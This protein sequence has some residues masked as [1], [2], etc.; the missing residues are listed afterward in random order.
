MLLQIPPA[1]R[2]NNAVPPPLP[3]PTVSHAIR[4]CNESKVNGFVVRGHGSLLE[5]LRHSRV[6]MACARNVFR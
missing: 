5:G 1:E 6:R 2:G 4:V 3:C